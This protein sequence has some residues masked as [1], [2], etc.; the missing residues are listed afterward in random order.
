MKNKFLTSLFISLI[1]LSFTV[2]AEI[3]TPGKALTDA[4]AFL[5]GLVRGGVTIEG[6]YLLSFVLYF[7]VFMAIFV[8]GVK[9]L[10][11]FGAR[12]EV[13]G[14]GKWFAFAAAGLATVGIFFTEKALGKGMK[15]IVESVVMPFG[16]WGGIVIAGIIAF[17][18]YK[19][20]RDVGIFKDS[21]M[22]AMALALSIGLMI[23][24]WLLSPALFGWAF[25]LWIIIFGF[26][27]VG[28]VVNHF[29]KRDKKLAEKG[30]K[31][32][33]KGEEVPISG[34]KKGGKKAAKKAG[35]K[36]KKIE[37][38]EAAEESFTFEE[39]KIVK[40][41]FKNL[42][43]LKKLI[44]EFKPEEYKKWA[45]QVEPLFDDIRDDLEE[46]RDYNGKIQR[47]ARKIRRDF[48]KLGSGDLEEKETE[49]L[50]IAQIIQIRLQD[51]IGQVSA[52]RGNAA[53]IGHSNHPPEEYIKIITSDLNIIESSVK[54]LY[55]RVGM[56]FKLEKEVEKKLNE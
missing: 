40:E 39:L 16:F 50:A 21:V 18:S 3:P 5:V 51:D 36:V 42:K 55:E 24:G 22:K 52:A 54:E 44:P 56:L 15:E 48:R 17:I 34:G 10:P 23:T 12:G 38:E 6:M 29:G 31:K 53:H 41:V 7:I 11:F 33:W 25:Y 26:G 35:K 30:L 37:K 19:G 47:L 4:G 1:A 9:Y 14:S 49:I 27:F 28:Y 20:I 46:F 32:N 45:A 8:E 13:S 2:L 43:T